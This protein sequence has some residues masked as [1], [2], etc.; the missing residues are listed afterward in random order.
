MVP[1]VPPAPALR[2]WF[3]S[4]D[5]ADADDRD[6]TSAAPGEAAPLPDP[7]PRLPGGVGLGAAAADGECARRLRRP[8]SLHS[9][10]TS[11]PPA[12]VRST[13]ESNKRCN[14][15]LSSRLT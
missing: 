12:R 3:F 10:T 15:E 13:S 6:G 9:E 2:A 1:T 8:S 14:H 7:L 4:E 5:D 11:P